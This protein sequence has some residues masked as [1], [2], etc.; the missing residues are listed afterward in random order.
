MRPITYAVGDR[1]GKWTLLTVGEPRRGNRIVEARCDCGTTRRLFINTLREGKSRQC[2]ACCTLTRIGRPS[3]RRLPP[4]V[5]AQRRLARAAYEREWKRNNPEKHR[6]QMRRYRARYPEKN[7][8]HNMVHMAQR[9]GRVVRQGCEICGSPAEA[10]HEN[11]ARP[12]DVK[13]LCRRHH[14]EHHQQQKG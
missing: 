3:P 12:L 6:A 2:R 7:R 14:Q 11:Y 10:H 9:A 5:K 4:E 13:W 8:A 1:F